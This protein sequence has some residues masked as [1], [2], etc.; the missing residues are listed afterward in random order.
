[1]IFSSRFIFF[2]LIATARPSV[3]FLTWMKIYPIFET[4]SSLFFQEGEPDA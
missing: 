2:A 4:L 3:L 1:M